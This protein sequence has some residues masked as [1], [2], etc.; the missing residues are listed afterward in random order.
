MRLNIM[1]DSI[2]LTPDL[3]LRAYSCGFFPMADGRDCNEFY[4]LNPE[5]RGV[6]PF[7][8][9]HISH[10]LQKILKKNVFEVLWDTQFEKVIDAC[11]ESY[12]KR[13]ETWINQEIRRVFVE[14]FYLGY[15]HSVEVYQEGKLVGGL[16]GL[17][18][19]GAF[20]G[21][22]M[23]NRVPNA[24]KIALVSLVDRLKDKG[25][26]LLD[27]QFLNPFLESFGA[28]EIDKNIY[29]KY[30]EEALKKVV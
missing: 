3:I 23:F 13:Q 20:F 22:S 28:V 18:L 8:K 26:S 27:T 19:G 11:A 16:Y 12:H 4:W 5:K 2:T 6:L 1:S 24:A 30:L 9:F 14:L 7:D 25:Y 15:A 29:L 21:E 10:S 17:S